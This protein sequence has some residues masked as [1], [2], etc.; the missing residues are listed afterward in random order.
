MYEML[1]SALLEGLAWPD[2]RHLAAA[3]LVDVISGHN[4]VTAIRHPLGFLCLPVE[5]AGER[6]VCVHLWTDRLRLA[7]PATPTTSTTHAHS[8]DLL[9]CVLFGSLYNELVGIAED[10]GRPTHRVFEVGSR[11]YGDELRRTGQLVRGRAGRRNLHRDGEVY[12]LPAGAFH[13]TVPVGE[14]ATLVLGSGQPDAADL[15]LGDVDT[16]THRVRR[17]RCT[18]EETVQAAT[19]IAS[20][21]A[22]IPA[23]R[24]REDRCQPRSC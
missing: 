7:V 19:M 2:V 15:V 6:G 8:W 1:H 10:G 22:E 9:S 16:P 5:R 11:P 4:R 12:T 21:L 18:R 14:V 24:H 23:P 3:V 17:S 20:R 13:R